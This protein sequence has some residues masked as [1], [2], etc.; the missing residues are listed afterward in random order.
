MRFADHAKES[1]FFIFAVDCPLGVEN[2]M[3]AVLRIGLREHHEF[4]ISRI[5]VGFR[6]GVRE[7]VDFVFAH[8]Q[9]HRE[10]GISERLTAV[11]QKINR[12]HGFA[13]QFEE[14]LF[15]FHISVNN[16]FCHAVMKNTGHTGKNFSF[17]S[18]AREVDVIERSPFNTKDHVQAAVMRN[19]RGFTGPRADCAQARNHHEGRI[20]LHISAIGA[21]MQKRLQTGAFIIG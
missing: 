16:A 3:T 5:A 2:L 7:V 9:A 12:Y 14:N 19:I 8:G 18:V 6:E 20:G 17:R 15:S 11:L 4:N 13:G 1:L 21:I 10:V